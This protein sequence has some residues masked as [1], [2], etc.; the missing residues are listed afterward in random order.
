MSQER[1]EGRSEGIRED[2][3]RVATD[4]LRENLPLQLIAKISKLS[5][6][7]IRGIAGN[8]GLAVM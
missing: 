4:M 5:E 6:D 2:R 3:Q 1:Q 7:V 8:L